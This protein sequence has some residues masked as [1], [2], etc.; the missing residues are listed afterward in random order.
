MII[1]NGFGRGRNCKFCVTVG[2]VIW[3]AIIL[4]YCKLASLGLTLIDSKVKGDEL[5]R[6]GPHS[7]CVN[8]LLLLALIIGWTPWYCY[9]RAWYR[10]YLQKYSD[11]VGGMAQWLERRSLTDELSLIYSWSMVDMWPL[12]GLGLRYGSTNQA[13][14]AFHPFGVGKWVVI[15]VITWITGV[16]TIKRQTGTVRVVI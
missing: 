8:L 7:L 10:M 6:D 16:E 2:P 15:H 14:S 3:S 1:G 9:D 4:A 12:R 5:R 13:N 11:I